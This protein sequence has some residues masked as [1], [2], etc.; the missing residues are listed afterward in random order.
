MTMKDGIRKMQK[1]P[2]FVFLFE[3]ANGVYL[4]Q[5]TFEPYEICDLND[6]PLRTTILHTQLHRNSSFL[7]I[8]RL[9]YFLMH[10]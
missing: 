7:E 9:Q 4:I 1:N 2:G 10:Y 8:M 3:D 6:I 5:K